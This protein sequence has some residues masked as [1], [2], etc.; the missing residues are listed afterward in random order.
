MES[1]SLEMKMNIP[2]LVQSQERPL[3]ESSMPNPLTALR[4]PSAAFGGALA[5]CSPTF[6][7]KAI[8]GRIEEVVHAHYILCT[9]VS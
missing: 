2:R 1:L 4:R 8:G 6:A 3:A 5:A 7:I 9:G